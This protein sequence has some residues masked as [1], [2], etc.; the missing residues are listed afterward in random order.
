MPCQD[1]GRAFSCAGGNLIRTDVAIGFKVS[2]I[3][4]QLC[5]FDKN[6]IRRPRTKT[7]ILMDKK[8]KKK[9]DVLRK[10]I[11]KTQQQ[12][13][14]AKLQPDEPDEVENLQKEIEKMR[15]E[16]DKLKAS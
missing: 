11:E 16:I 1:S 10:R 7:K 15:A 5:Q 9:I 8:T 12:V 14:G 13:A 4:V 3:E 2:I 6:I